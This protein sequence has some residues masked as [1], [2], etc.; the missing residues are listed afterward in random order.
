MAIALLLALLGMGNKLWIS[1]LYSLCIGNLASLMVNGWA[2]FAIAHWL[3]RPARSAPCPTCTRT[4]ARL[5]LDGAADVLVGGTLAYLGGSWLA[6]DLISG[7][8]SPCDGIAP[9]TGRA[10]W[11]SS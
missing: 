3:L 9:M 7:Q 4:L 6:Q 2:A 1:L 8:R 11:A 5:A 10:G